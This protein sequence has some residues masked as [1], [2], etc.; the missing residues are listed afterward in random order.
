MPNGSLSLP[1]RLYLLAWDTTRLKVTGATHLHHLVR[2]GALTELAQRGLLVDDDGIV[3]PVDADSRTGDAVLDG[4]LE[5]VAESRPRKW[6]AWVTVRAARDTLDAVR[7]QLALEGYLRPEKKRVLGLF[8]SVEYKLEQVSAVDALHAEARQV[9]E[10]PLPVAEV[11]DRDAALIALAA[12]AEL[13][14]LVPTKDRKLHKT[15]IEALN[16]RSGAAT[17]ALAKAIQEVRAAIIVAVTAGA[18]TGAAAG[19]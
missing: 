12:A 11:S 14:S 1:A 17:P 2:A 8:P 18:A 13:R 5:L 10:G 4:L 15:R 19:S 9:L 16:E 6:K 7:A 3:T